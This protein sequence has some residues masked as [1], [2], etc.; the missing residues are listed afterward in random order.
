MIQFD[1]MI[2][3]CQSVFYQAGIQVFHHGFIEKLINSANTCFL[4]AVF[5]GRNMANRLWHEACCLKTT[6]IFIVVIFIWLTY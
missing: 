5:N 1:E 3:Y 4:S 6:F 2:N